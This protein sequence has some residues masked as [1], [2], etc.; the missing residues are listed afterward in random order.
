MPNESL[1]PTLP[2]YILN[3]LPILASDILLSLTSNR[4][5]AVFATGAI[6]GSSF[7]MIQYPLVTYVYSEVSSNQ[8]FVWPS[9][10]SAT[11]FGMLDNIYPLIIGPALTM[12]IV[13]ALLARKIL[14]VIVAG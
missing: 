13:G 5:C 11:Y 8:S 3:I 2:F 1:I 7:L 9:L 10:I 14:R 4:P 12:G 6:L